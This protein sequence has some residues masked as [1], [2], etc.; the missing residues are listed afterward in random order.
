MGV[1]DIKSLLVK[2]ATTAAGAFGSKVGG[3]VAGYV[4]EMVGLQQDELADVRASLANIQSSLVRI[5]NE[6]EQIGSKI[7]WLPKQN[8]YLA[9]KN[10]V[11][12][13]WGNVSAILQGNHSAAERD[14]LMRNYLG[15]LQIGA[16]ES[17]MSGISG[18]VDG[19]ANLLPNGNSLPGELYQNHWAVFQDQSLVEASDRAMQI[20]YRISD[21]QYKGAILAFNHYMFAPT[22]Q[23]DLARAAISQ[24]VVRLEAHYRLFVVEAPSMMAYYASGFPLAAGVGGGWDVE[25]KSVATGVSKPYLQAEPLIFLDGKLQRQLGSAPGP[26]TMYTSNLNPLRFKLVRKGSYVPMSFSSREVVVSAGTYRH[27]IPT[28][29]GR[30]ISIPG[31]GPRYNDEDLAVFIMDDWNHK[32]VAQLEV[33]TTKDRDLYTLHDQQGKY[34]KLRRWVVTP[35]VTQKGLGGQK[36]LNNIRVGRGGKDAD[37]IWDMR[38]AMTN[39]NFFNAVH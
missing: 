10:A 26:L 20:L 3:T 32:D 27:S 30:S 7:D 14:R 21:L 16:L 6:I 34:L 39:E 11:D 17:A 24:M 35:N 12:P 2:A 37:A 18:M 19:S 29:K 28:R 36:P 8:A 23:P 38:I 22:A 4:L 9:L 33:T 31:S 13:A 1:I 15:T 25:I 5:E